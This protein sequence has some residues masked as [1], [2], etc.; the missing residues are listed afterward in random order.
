MGESG[1]TASST[2]PDA[3]TLSAALSH[4]ADRIRHRFPGLRHERVG[5]CE[6]L[7]WPGDIEQLCGWIG[8]NLDK[9]AT[10][11]EKG[12]AFGIIVKKCSD[13]LPLSI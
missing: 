13:S 11:G 8:Q 3:S 12:G 6:H 4:D 9:A 7:D 10:V 1:C 5:G 2:P